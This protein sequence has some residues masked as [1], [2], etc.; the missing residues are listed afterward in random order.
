MKHPKLILFFIIG[1]LVCACSSVSQK[2]GVVNLIT[3]PSA[4]RGEFEIFVIYEER[5]KF[6]PRVTLDNPGAESREIGRLKTSG[7]VGERTV[8]IQSVIETGAPGIADLVGIHQF[9]IEAG[10]HH[11]SVNCGRSSSAIFDAE[12]KYGRLTVFLIYVKPS[13]GKSTTYL[14]SNGKVKT[15]TNKI[16]T[17]TPSHVADLSSRNLPWHITELFNLAK[18]E[19]FS[20]RLWAVES[21]LSRKFGQ[22]HAPGKNKINI[23]DK[24]LE[25][26]LVDIA[27][28]DPDERLRKYAALALDEFYSD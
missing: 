4:K 26:L 23:D 15:T 8:D 12:I 20:A 16:Y 25:K 10:T 21:L 17:C 7:F 2:K 19:K 13:Y 3:N 14:Y 18:S 28:D 1:P 9:I 22:S 11:F 5:T 27:S 6:P 24:K